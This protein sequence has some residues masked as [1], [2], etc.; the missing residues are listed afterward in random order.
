MQEVLISHKLHGL[1]RLVTSKFVIKLLTFINLLQSITLSVPPLYFEESSLI[2]S[3][4]G[5]NVR[6]MK[7]IFPSTLKGS[8]LI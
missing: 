3:Y 7:V 4:F 8:S 1:V 2:V 6:N 5:E